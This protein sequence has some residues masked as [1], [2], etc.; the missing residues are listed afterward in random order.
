MM[1]QNPQQTRRRSPFKG[2][3]ASLLPLDPPTPHQ[4]P[5]TQ[6]FQTSSTAPSSASLPPISSTPRTP[7]AGALAPT[8]TI[9]HPTPAPTSAPRQSILAPTSAQPYSTPAPT[10][11]SPRSPPPDTDAPSRPNLA[12]T[13]AYS[14]SNP[15]QTRDLHHSIRAPH[16]A[17]THPT[18]A[19]TGAPSQA[20]FTPTSTNLHSSPA[21]TSAPRQL[22]RAPPSATPY[23]TSA[24][25]S[26]LQLPPS[27]PT[28][29]L[30]PI[31]PPPTRGTPKC[32]Q[33][34]NPLESTAPPSFPSHPSRPTQ[35]PKQPKT[36]PKK[37]KPP[38]LPPLPPPPLPEEVSPEEIDSFLDAYVNPNR[39]RPLVAADLKVGFINIASLYG[40]TKLP[41]ILWL[42]D[43][44][45]L[46]IVVLVDVRS[47]D[48]SI[49]FLLSHLRGALGPGSR[50]K[51]TYGPP[52]HEETVHRRQRASHNSRVGGQVMLC[53]PHWG[54]FCSTTWADPS[55]LGLVIGAE[56]SPNPATRTLVMGVYIPVPPLRGADP[57][58]ASASLW[59]LWIRWAR[60]NGIRGTPLEWVKAYISTKIINFRN[61]HPEGTIV[62]GGDY[63]ATVGTG[64]GGVHGR[65]DTWMEDCH[66]SSAIHELGIRG[67]HTRWSGTT[68]T[69]HIDHILYDKDST[70]SRLVTAMVLE[71][72]VWADLSD[73]RWVLAGLSFAQTIPPRPVARPKPDQLVDVDLTDKTRV[74]LYQD[75]LQVATSREVNK[76]P[77][78]RLLD[79]CQLSQQTAR[80]VFGKRNVKH[81]FFNG[82][83]PHLIAYK[84]QAACLLEI[85]RCLT[86][87]HAHPKWTTAQVVPGIHQEVTRWV[88]T[89][90][91]LRWPDP[92]AKHQC[93]DAI[94]ECSPSALRLL[95]P[96]APGVLV[97]HLARWRQ[98][99]LKLLQGRSRSNFRRLMGANSRKIEHFRSIG[100]LKRVIPRIIARDKSTFSFDSLI[101]ADDTILTD[102]IQIHNSVAQ[103]FE[104]WFSGPPNS[105]TGIHD[106][107]T[108]WTTILTQEHTFHAHCANLNVPPALA[109]ILWRA[110]QTPAALPQYS[111]ASTHIAATLDNGVPWEEFSHHVR[112]MDTGTAPGWTGFTHAMMRA[113]PESLLREVHDH[114]QQFGHSGAPEWWSFRLLSPIQKVPGSNSLDTL[115]PI[116]LL[117]VL[118]K[119]WT[120]LLHRK[121]AHAWEQF[122]LL[123]QG[124]A[125]GRPSHSTEGPITQLI[126]YLDHRRQSQ[127]ATFVTFW[128]IARAFDSPSKNILR[129]SLA[130]LAVPTDWADWF[131][132]MDMKG[133]V[134]P[135]SPATTEFLNTGGVPWEA[136]PFDQDPSR[137]GRFST[138]RGCSQ[139]D[140]PSPSHWA[141]FFDILLRA[142]ELGSPEATV[143][144]GHHGCPQSLSDGAF[145]DDLTTVSPTYMSLQHKLDIVCA[146]AIVFSLS[147]NIPKLKLFRTPGVADH[148]PPH[149]TIHTAGWQPHTIPFT[150]DKTI[151]H[152]GYHLNHD[153]SDQHQFNLARSKIRQGCNILLHRYASPDT[154][155]IVLRTV[156]FPQTLYAAKFCQWSLAQCRALDVPVEALYRIITKNMASFP[157]LLLYIPTQFGGLGL[158]RLSDQL[159]HEKWQMLHRLLR[160]DP[161]TQAAA[162]YFIESTIQAAGLTMPPGAAAIVSTETPRPT[163]LRSMIEWGTES[164]L[165]LWSGGRR[166][167]VSSPDIPLCDLYAESHI[168]TKAL[169][170]RMIE[171][172]CLTVGDLRQWTP[173]GWVW[174]DPHPILPQDFMSGSTEDR[175]TIPDPVRLRQGQCWTTETGIADIIACSQHMV[176]VTNW[177]P[178]TTLRVFQQVS[179]ALTTTHTPQE[180][181]AKLGPRPARVFLGPPKNSSRQIL[182]M[183]PNLPPL[184]TCPADPFLQAFNAIQ[185]LPWSGP[186]LIYTDGSFARTGSL[187]QTVFGSPAET[188]HRGGGGI[189]LIDPSPNWTTAPIVLIQLD[190][191]EKNALQAQSVFPYELASIILG[192]SI[193]SHFGYHTH[194][195][196]DSKSSMDSLLK[197]RKRVDSAREY[198]PLIAAGKSLLRS[199]RTT[200]HKIAAHPERQE[201]NHHRWDRHQWGNVFADRIAGGQS[202]HPIPHGWNPSDVKRFTVPAWRLLQHTMCYMPLVWVERAVDTPLVL[203][204]LTAVRLATFNRYLQEREDWSARGGRFTTWFDTSPWVGATAAKLSS[205]PTSMAASSVRSIWNKLWIGT[206]RTKTAELTP[207]QTDF[208]ASCEF[209]GAADQN[210]DHLL[211]H[212][213]APSFTAIRTKLYADLAHRI[214]SYPVSPTPCRQF[215]RAIRD[216]ALR[217][218]AGTSIWTGLWR[219]EVIDVLN[220]EATYG[221]SLSVDDVRALTKVTTEIGQLFCYATSAISNARQNT[222]M[223]PLHSQKL[224]TEFQ[225]F[226]QYYPRIQPR[227]KLTPYRTKSRA[228][229]NLSN[230][231]PT[232]LPNTRGLSRKQRNDRIRN[233]LASCRT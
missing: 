52:G 143:L 157:A 152:L 212:C 29:A 45:Q 129:A 226:Q 82:W 26:T 106:P 36:K 224:Q 96:L 232:P 44:A 139:G 159:Q 140:P 223:T 47:T 74:A 110:V 137:P 126:A 182:G 188:T 165:T 7:T 8:D 23:S 175:T 28:R 135:K 38:T 173:D 149:M 150:K 100:K 104:T 42:M 209:C 227:C 164:G 14:Y 189:V 172:G 97:Q 9:S 121:V 138:K 208:L 179:Q 220:T 119:V 5:I 132:S 169:R 84:A 225:E 228:E 207:T 151:R 86:G 72:S 27:A 146:F 113:W 87:A 62:C 25:T 75:L 31:H 198:Y 203:P 128:D 68:P 65:L 180:F 57:T 111:E 171:T 79:I 147:V 4:T 63:N 58:E 142:L 37:K 6:F 127:S 16:S 118:R 178:M 99:V 191:R 141:A 221:P 177:R 22:I 3:H 162:W 77:G 116:M 78:Q 115:R 56:F 18:P 41:Y 195:Y 83:S 20:I 112:H 183:L 222:P 76:D 181:L 204:P 93:M 89:V 70:A 200:L 136:P 98:S 10:S 49:P 32:A 192:L 33:L 92:K 48:A 95:Q 55:G 1:K 233:H 168:F 51:S 194:I 170:A 2:R 231:R 215:A 130:R 21:S 197:P 176:Q 184:Y 214:G 59:R 35:N 50:A 12:P 103:H 163:F 60:S 39:F 160:S 105:L 109:N 73:H 66:L 71:E 196:T 91:S 134:L 43:R 187:W 24:A 61:R 155:K 53:S 230:Q 54:R 46:D 206:N 158:P 107:A 88:N 67:V 133:G 211:R 210:E 153:G 108:D 123:A 34:R 166:D 80:R 145:V 193:C 40:S 117:E 90:E 202:L 19:P 94:P 218:P 219:S 85:Q 15:V 229:R 125:G 186:P 190:D 185:E 69:G 124:Q 144:P 64:P 205:L 199:T 213:P 122:N 217:H 154:K 156:I 216:L 11:A 102:P 114:L 30:S 101:L 174:R 17:T 81:R 131:V 167:R 13:S 161:G 201:P 148:H 120:T